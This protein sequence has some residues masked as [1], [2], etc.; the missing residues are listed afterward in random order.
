[1][2]VSVTKRY[3]SLASHLEIDV[4]ITNPIAGRTFSCKALWDTGA[5]RSMISKSAADE[6][7]LQIL[8]IAWMEGFHGEDFRSFHDVNIGV[9]KGIGFEKVR[10]ISAHSLGGRHVLLGMDIITKL[11]FHISN[12]G[13]ITVHSIRF[14]SSQTIDFEDQSQH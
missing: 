4:V 9:A 2:R 1:M 6:L 10:V 8:G 5:Q 14:P 12:V 7:Q 3:D 11:D 13:E